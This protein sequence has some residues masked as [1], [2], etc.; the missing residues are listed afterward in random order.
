MSLYH[1]IVCATFPEH[2]SLTRGGRLL[3][4]TGDNSKVEDLSDCGADDHGGGQL[5]EENST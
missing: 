4:A 3:N 1:L 5:V 2:I